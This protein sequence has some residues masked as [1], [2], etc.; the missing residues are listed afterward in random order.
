MRSSSVAVEE[1]QLWQPWQPE[2]RNA[3]VKVLL[4]MKTCKTCKSSAAG[5]RLQSQ[6]RE[7]S[8]CPRS[9]RSMEGGSKELW[10]STGGQRSLLALIANSWRSSREPVLLDQWCISPKKW[11]MGNIFCI[12]DT[13]HLK[14]DWALWEQVGNR[15]SHWWCVYGRLGG[16]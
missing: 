16:K 1:E 8:I 4:Q 9:L 6:H 3:N 5:T 11:F 13:S 10:R 2:I 12:N 15:K 14:N 7:R